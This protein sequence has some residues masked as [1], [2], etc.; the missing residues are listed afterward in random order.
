MVYPDDEL[1]EFED[2][3][4]ENKMYGD[5]GLFNQEGHDELGKITQRK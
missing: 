4:M 1:Q 3:S 5:N 2:M